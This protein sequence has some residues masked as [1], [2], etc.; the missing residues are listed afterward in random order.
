MSRADDIATLRAGGF[1]FRKPPSE[2]KTAY[3]QRQASGMRRGVSSSQ[4]RRGH[5]HTPEHRVT[6]IKGR[7]HN[8]YYTSGKRKG[9][10]KR[11]ARM[12]QWK[13]HDPYDPK[14]LRAALKKV[15]SG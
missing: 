14:D 2:Y 15:P 7:G 11:G 9:E 8:E 3:L 13:T 12:E 1:R 4:A 5:A 6:K 10:V